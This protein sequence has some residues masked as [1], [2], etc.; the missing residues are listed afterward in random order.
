MEVSGSL[1][2]ASATVNQDVAYMSALSAICWT[3]AVRPLSDTK[4]V[5][6]ER[7][8]KKVF[9][10]IRVGQAM[11]H[12]QCKNKACRLSAKIAAFSFLLVQM[13]KT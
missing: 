6:S 1:A 2:Y 13:R 4:S 3:R 5:P 8:S 9:V 10:L 11:S 12:C 7:T